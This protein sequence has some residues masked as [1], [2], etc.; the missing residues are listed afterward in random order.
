MLELEAS[1]DVG[2]TDFG[3]RYMQLKDNEIVDSGSPKGDHVP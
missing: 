3:D 2:V 1:F